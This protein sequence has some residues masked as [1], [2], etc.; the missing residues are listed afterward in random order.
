MKELQKDLRDLRE[1]H[2]MTQSEIAEKLEVTP[3]AVGWWEH[4][5]AIPSRRVRDPY[6]KLLGLRGGAELFE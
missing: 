6:A 2:N 5:K 3:R 1:F 4:G